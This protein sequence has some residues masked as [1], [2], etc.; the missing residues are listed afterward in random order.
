M[1]LLLHLISQRLNKAEA[2]IL[3]E[4]IKTCLQLVNV[5][6][7]A[8]SFTYLPCTLVERGDWQQLSEV[9]MDLPSRLVPHHH[10]LKL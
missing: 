1:A 9:R 10:G 3:P 5:P 8:P 6:V 4:G 7:S 2:N